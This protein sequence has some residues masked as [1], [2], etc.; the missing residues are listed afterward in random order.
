[1]DIFKRFLVVIAL[2]IFACSSA[3]AASNIYDDTYTE[4]DS[5]GNWTFRG[6]IQATVGTVNTRRNVYTIDAPAD[7][8]NTVRAERSGSIYVLRSLTGPVVGGVGYTVD[9]P[10]AA[11]GL[12]YTF[13][14][15]TNQTLAIRTASASDVFVTATT[16][17]TRTR[18][19]SPASTGCTVTLTGASGKWYIASMSTPSYANGLK[20]DW[21]TGNRTTTTL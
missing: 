14:T 21:E 11:S 6:N 3:F 8:V 4:E 2:M 13:S 1:M 10:A 18:L 9:L 19:L 17:T 16:G 12:S 7:T 20:N 5:T 15:A